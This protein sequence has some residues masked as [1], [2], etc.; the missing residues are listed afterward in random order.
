MV[1]ELTGQFNSFFDFWK[2]AEKLLFPKAPKTVTAPTL[3][4][5]APALSLQKR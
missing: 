2:K 4:S 3:F 5:T 1:P